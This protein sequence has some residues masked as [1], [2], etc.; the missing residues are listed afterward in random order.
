MVNAVRLF[1]GVILC[2]FRARRELLLE[3]LVL[4][5]QL[6]VLKTKT[7]Q[8]KTGGREPKEPI[9]RLPCVRFAAHV[10]LPSVN[11]LRSITEIRWQPGL[12]LPTG[13]QRCG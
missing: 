10:C 12:C 7:S 5:Q 13:V 2:L 11:W 1:A 3:N 6:M 8:A 4:R 9:C